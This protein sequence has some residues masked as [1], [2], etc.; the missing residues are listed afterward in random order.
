MLVFG[1]PHHG[2]QVD[3][4]LEGVLHLQQVSSAM[5]DAL[6]N[7]LANWLFFDNLSMPIVRLA[8]PVCKGT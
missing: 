4:F 7:S 2:K 6:D 5:Q 3:P 8:P 1:L